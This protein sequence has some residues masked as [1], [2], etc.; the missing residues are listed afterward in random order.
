VATEVAPDAESDLGSAEATEASA[1]YEFREL[2]RRQGGKALRE[3][4][5]PKLRCHPPRALARQLG[6]PARSPSLTPISNPP[7]WGI[8]NY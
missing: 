1:S 4:F 2:G 6:D 8:L 5:L 3:E 7:W